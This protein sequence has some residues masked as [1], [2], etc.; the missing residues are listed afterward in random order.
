M[1]QKVNKENLHGFIDFMTEPGA[2][3]FTDDLHA[4]RGLPNHTAVNHSASQYVDGMAHTQGIE[5][6]W[7]MLKRGYQG[8]YHKMSLKHLGRY[9]NEFQGRHNFRRKGTAA[10]MAAV[11][12]GIVGRRLMYRDLIAKG[13]ERHADGSDVF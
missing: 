8:T 6:F 10:Q 9:V 3:V 2:E 12:S 4:Y 11:A 1:L 7:A 5:S 13:A